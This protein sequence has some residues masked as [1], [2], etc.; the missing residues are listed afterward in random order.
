MKKSILLSLPMLILMA[1]NSDSGSS[2]SNTKEVEKIMDAFVNVYV[3]KED[4]ILDNIISH[5]PDIVFY[6]FGTT[7]M[8]GYKSIRKTI[9]KS[10]EKVEDSDINVRDRKVKIDGDIA[11]FSQRADWNYD[12]DNQRIE[13][14]GIR[15]TGVLRNQD[16]GWKIVQ[17]HT[18]M[19]QR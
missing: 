14:K 4:K 13:A 10:I 2:S 12:W 11:W 3:D 9:S 5:D 16:G 19:P 18:S 7:T 8:K 15:M 6:T 1:C 17:W